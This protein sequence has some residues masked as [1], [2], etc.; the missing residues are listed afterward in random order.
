M[1][2]QEKTIKLTTFSIAEQHVFIVVRGCIVITPE[3]RDISHQ[4]LEKGLET[5]ES[6][7]NC[8]SHHTLHLVQS[9]KILFNSGE[10]RA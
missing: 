8:R 3:R 10:V 5:S 2:Y 9:S 7:I 4:S 1:F 6:F